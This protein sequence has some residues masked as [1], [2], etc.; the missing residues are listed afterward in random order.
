VAVGYDNALKITN[1]LNNRRLTGA[2]LI[3]IHG[4]RHGACRGYGWIPYDYA[5]RNAAMDFWSLLKMEWWI[6]RSFSNR[7]SPGRGGRTHVLGLRPP[8]FFP[9]EQSQKKRQSGWNGC[10]YQADKWSHDGFPFADTIE[11]RFRK[12]HRLFISGPCISKIAICF[13]MKGQ[14]FFPTG[15]KAGFGGKT[16]FEFH[17]DMRDP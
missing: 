10:R 4:E 12:I 9:L 14:K 2:F 15:R 8:R 5:I 1:S 6:R 13:S 3:R 17:A 7:H 16:A 11:I